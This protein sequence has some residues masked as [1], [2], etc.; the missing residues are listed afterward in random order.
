MES[1]EF[2]WTKKTVFVVSLVPTSVI[3]SILGFVYF[4]WPLLV[5]GPILFI[6]YVLLDP[7]CE[8]D[9]ILEDKVDRYKQELNDITG[10]ERRATPEALRSKTY[11]G[12]GD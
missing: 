8:K 5:I 12:G 11:K 6:A 1:Q 4:F 9:M 3:C 7:R 2:K 10:E